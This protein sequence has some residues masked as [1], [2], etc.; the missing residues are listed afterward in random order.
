MGRH[1]R[2]HES[3]HSWHQYR[4]TGRKGICSGAGWR[5]HDHSVRA[6]TGHEHL[7]DIELISVQAGQSCL[8]NNS[9]V[10]DQITSAYMV[11]AAQFAMHQR[12]ML[13]GGMALCDGIEHVV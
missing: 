3:F 11:A 1:G 13:N 4:S 9:V 5:S 6:I 12:P 2:D 8:V 10:K 7:I